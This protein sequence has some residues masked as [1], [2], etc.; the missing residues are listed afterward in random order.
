MEKKIIFFLLIF[1]SVTLGL[2]SC[3]SDEPNGSI[4]KSDVVGSW[5]AYE[6]KVDGSWINI[7]NYP[8]LAVSI[9]FNSDGTY[10]GKGALGTGSGTWELSNNTIKTYVSGSLYITY[11]IKSLSNGMGEVTA[12]DKSGSIDMKIRKK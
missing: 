7:S 12:V 6:V 4:T 1:L 8:S 2:T 5:E 3:S 9:T 10:Y 11:N